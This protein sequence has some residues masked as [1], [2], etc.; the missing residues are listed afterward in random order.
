MMKKEVIALGLVMCMVLTSCGRNSGKNEVPELM[1]PVNSVS[2]TVK[3]EVGDIENTEIVTGEIIPYTEELSFNR[4]GFVETVYVR[5]G[6]HVKKGDKIA[7]MVGGT[8]NG[9]QNDIINEIDAKKRSYAVDNLDMEYDI[10]ILKLEKKKLQDSLKKARKKEKSDIKNQINIKEVDIEIAELKYESQKENQQ[11]E[12]DELE[13]KKNAV[14]KDV[15]EY[16]LY[17]GMDGIVSFIEATNGSQVSRGSLVA[18]VS[19]INRFHVRS[20][21]VSNNTYSQ[22]KRCYI[23]C[24]GKEYDVTMRPYDSKEV[25]E[26]LEQG[27]PVS[28]FFDIKDADS[29][30]TMGKNVDVHVEL[31]SSKNTLLVPV[32][33]VYTDNGKSYVYRYVDGAKIKTDVKKGVENSTY[34]EILSGLEEGDDI[35]VQP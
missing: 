16:F 31:A 35:Y 21:F 20:D 9:E 12:F 13:R 28:S 29:S 3:V 33:A 7:V 1:E 25:D 26:R 2:S 8:D 17:S 22:S 23:T 24:D 27:L 19:D 18:A 4:D 11:I 32:N 5:E 14:A 30:L 34:I 10:K 15:E 6:D